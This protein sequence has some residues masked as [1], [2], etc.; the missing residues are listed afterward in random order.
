MINK[1]AAR[2]GDG[3]RA[4]IPTGESESIRHPKKED[5]HDHSHENAVWGWDDKDMPEEDIKD[6]QIYNKGD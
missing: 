5:L 2:S 1:R 4:P 3:S 6:A